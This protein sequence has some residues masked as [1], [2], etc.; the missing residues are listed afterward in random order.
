MPDQQDRRQI[1]IDRADRALIEQAAAQ[2]RQGAIRAGYA[3]IPGQHFAFGLALV[4]DELAL[5]LRD[6]DAEL[7]ARPRRRPDAHRGLNTPPRGSRTTSAARCYPIRRGR[8]PASTAPAGAYARPG[9]TE[10]RQS[11]KFQQ[12]LAHI[13][14]SSLGRDAGGQ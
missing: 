1:A 14:R 11:W 8:M 3:G 9:P 12:G 7:R 4:L 5:H 2:L 10:S 13:V 6:L